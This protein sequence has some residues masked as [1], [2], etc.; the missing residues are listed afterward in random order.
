[1]VLVEILPE[2]VI[3]GVYEINQ[4]ET[5]SDGSEGGPADSKMFIALL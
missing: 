4:T 3:V 1:M 5:S 2:D